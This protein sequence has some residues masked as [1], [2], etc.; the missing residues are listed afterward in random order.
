MLREPSAREEAAGCMGW[1]PWEVA[2]RLRL[3]P[4]LLLPGQVKVPGSS[5]CN[6]LPVLH[7]LNMKRRAHVI[8]A[9]IAR[10]VSICFLCQHLTCQFRNLVS[11]RDY[12]G[13]EKNPENCHP[14][15]VQNHHVVNIPCKIW[16]CKMACDEMRPFLWHLLKYGLLCLSSLFVS[17]SPMCTILEGAV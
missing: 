15:V 14:S 9:H 13:E 6:N 8:A 12:L 17:F 10:L 1:H 11:K 7:M 16:D 2:E 3:S 4:D 5:S